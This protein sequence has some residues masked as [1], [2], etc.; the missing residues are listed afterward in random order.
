M[1]VEKVFRY[2]FELSTIPCLHSFK[3]LRKLVI[4]IVLQTTSQIDNLQ[5]PLS[6]FTSLYGHL[7]I[8]NTLMRLLEFCCIS[9]FA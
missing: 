2:I 8:S 3:L 7:H 5:C 4:Y 9:F 6:A 1:S